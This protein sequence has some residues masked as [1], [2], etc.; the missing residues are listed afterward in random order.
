MKKIDIDEKKETDNRLTWK[1]LSDLP[2]DEKKRLIKEHGC[3]YI[4]D[5]KNFELFKIESVDL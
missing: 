1:D 2:N 4:F 5:S 3:I